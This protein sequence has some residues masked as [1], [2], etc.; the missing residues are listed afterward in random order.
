MV[1]INKKIKFNGTGTLKTPDLTTP[2]PVD[3]TDLGTVTF[4]DGV[5]TAFPQQV[6]DGRQF[7]LSVQAGCRWFWVYLETP[8]P[9]VDMTLGKSLLEPGES[10][11]LTWRSYNASKIYWTDFGATTLD[12]SMTVGVPRDYTLVVVNEGGDAGG[13]TATLKYVNTSA[14][15]VGT[16][17]H[18]EPNYHVVLTI[19]ADK[20]Y[21]WDAVSDGTPSWHAGTCNW[22]DGPSSGRDDVYYKVTASSNPGYI[23]YEDYFDILYGDYH[24]KREA[25]ITTMHFT[26]GF[27]KN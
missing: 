3:M 20:T 24:A 17:V 10:T 16:W 18:D 2:D 5:I 11:T 14:L 4:H 19:N 22:A 1:W 26:V 7:Y 15:V 8:E 12:G 27:N 13:E 6:A 9:F 23:G 25:S 21:R